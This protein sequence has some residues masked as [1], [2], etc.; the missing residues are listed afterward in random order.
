MNRATLRLRFLLRVGNWRL[1][2]RIFIACSAFKDPLIPCLLTITTISDRFLST[3]PD[4]GV[5]LC[6]G[7]GVLNFG[8][9]LPCP[10]K[11]DGFRKTVLQDW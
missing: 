11:I 9:S 4:S 1:L 10:I 7:D 8:D 2:R 3:G 6:L 5:T